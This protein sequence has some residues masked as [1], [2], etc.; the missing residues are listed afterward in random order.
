MRKKSLNTL[1]VSA[2]LLT[3]MMGPEISAMSTSL[4]AELAKA[5]AAKVEAGLAMYNLNCIAC[6]TLNKGGADGDGP[7][8]WGV[9]GRQAG[10]KANFAFSPELSS[11]GIVWSPELLARFIANPS[12]L[13]PGTIM[14]SAPVESDVDRAALIAFLQTRT[15]GGEPSPSQA[16]QVEAT[17][18]E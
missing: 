13:V 3:A 8:L 6:H 7:N 1:L 4:A 5:D 15:G 18:H 10:S 14:A 11:S 17:Q 12:E 9:F 2:M 16:Q